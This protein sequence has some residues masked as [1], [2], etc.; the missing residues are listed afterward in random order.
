MT[1][2]KAPTTIKMQQ[3]TA[4]L[5]K[6]IVNKRKE[7]GSLVTS[8]QGVTAQAIINLHKKECK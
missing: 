1:V 2:K 7:N 8:N 3:S 6:E 4:D 5:L